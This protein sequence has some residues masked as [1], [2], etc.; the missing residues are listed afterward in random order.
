MS[1][2]E[3]P[4]GRIVRVDMRASPE[5]S[6][7][8]LIVSP[9]CLGVLNELLPQFSSKQDFTASRS[10]PVDEDNND[11]LLVVNLTDGALVLSGDTGVKETIQPGPKH[12]GIDHLFSGATMDEV[13][14]GGDSPGTAQLLH[15]TELSVANNGNWQA[16]VV[17]LSPI[18]KLLVFSGPV[19]IANM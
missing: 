17:A 12:I 3:D 1:D 15:E 2:Q 14:V 19:R 13:L 9:L 5:A 7:S 11:A 6:S 8:D 4:E 10:H 18:R 16:E